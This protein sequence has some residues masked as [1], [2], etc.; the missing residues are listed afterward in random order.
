MNK[1]EYWEKIEKENKEIMKRMHPATLIPGMLVGVMVIVGC[2]LLIFG[3]PVWQL[4]NASPPPGSAA[5]KIPTA[6]AKETSL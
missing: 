5:S 4:F 6:A 3:I 1:K 2:I